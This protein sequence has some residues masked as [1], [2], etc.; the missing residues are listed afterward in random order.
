MSYILDA[1]RR[2]ESERER[3][4]VPTLHSQAVPGGP[5]GAEGRLAAPHSRVAGRWLGAAVGV[6]G[7]VTLGALGYRWLLSPAEVRPVA[8]PPAATMPRPEAGPPSAPAVLQAATPAPAPAPAPPPAAPAVLP[9]AAP[10]QRP[11]LAQPAVPQ[12]LPPSPAAATTV[13]SPSPAPEARVP[14][15]AELP[16]ALR[17]ELPALTASGAMYSDTPANRMLIINGQLLREGDQVGNQ[18]LV[19]EQIQLKR[20]VLS[21]KDQRFSISY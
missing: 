21:Y 14:A 15:L 13:R 17:R 19:L 16:E 4:H 2:A 1:L 12:R 6:L 7:L 18:H 10:V 5:A 3:G 8:A 9:A 11:P 20:A